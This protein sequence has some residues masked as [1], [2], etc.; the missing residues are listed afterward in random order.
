M[1]VD[2]A[3]FMS[4]YI[5][6]SLHELPNSFEEARRLAAGEREQVRPHHTKGLWGRHSCVVREQGAPHH[7]TLR[8][9]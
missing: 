6:R 7:S 5:P 1:D 9:P 8:L 4:A 2:D 3:V